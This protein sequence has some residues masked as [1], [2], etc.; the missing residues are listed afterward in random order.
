MTNNEIIVKWLYFIDDLCNKWNVD[1]DCRSMIIE[2]ILL[3]D[4]EI[5]S[6]LDETEEM[7]YWL[8][9]FIKNYWFSKTSRYYY[10][11]Q[12]YYDTYSRLSEDEY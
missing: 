10:T 12:K 3:Y 1:E 9:R 2:D 11:Y 8:V 6:K 7:K 4:N 5:L